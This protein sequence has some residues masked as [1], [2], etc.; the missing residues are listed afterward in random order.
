M[1][2]DVVAVD[3]SNAA[4]D[5]GTR[6]GFQAW[7]SPHWPAMAHFAARLVG[8][9]DREDVVQDALALAWRKRDRFDASRGSARSWLLA[10]VADQARKSHRRAAR[11]P[12]SVTLPD[13]DSGGQVECSVDVERAIRRLSVRQKLA[14]DLYYFLDLPVAEVAAV[15]GC[16]EGTAKS[17]LADARTRLH[18]YLGDEP[19]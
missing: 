19:Q 13:L 14:V 11:R 6:E 9:V 16:S 17:T 5:I 15:M 10:L 3:Q 7:V 12:R 1:E 4:V 2:R 8:T 18:D